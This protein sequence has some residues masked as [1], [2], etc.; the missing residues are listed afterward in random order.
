[1][2]LSSATT[3]SKGGPSSDGNEGVLFISQSSSITE[4]LPSD[5]FVSYAVHSFAVWGSNRSAE[6]QTVY[7]VTPTDEAINKL[8]LICL[9]TSRVIVST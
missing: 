1:M 4:T 9:H 8:E 3:P 5:C 7:S 6:V 2:T